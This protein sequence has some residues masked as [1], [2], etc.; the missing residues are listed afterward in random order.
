[1]N[2][3]PPLIEIF[4]IIAS[5]R[6]LAIFSLFYPLPVKLK[7]D[8]SFFIELFSLILKL[9]LKINQGTKFG[10]LKKPSFSLLDVII[11]RF[12][13]LIK[14]NIEMIIISIFCLI[15]PVKGANYLR[16]IIQGR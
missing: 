10:T 13:G 11:F 14:Q 7:I 4:K 2:N 8:S 1:M 5:P 12:T 16:A 15:I 6:P 9:T 3:C